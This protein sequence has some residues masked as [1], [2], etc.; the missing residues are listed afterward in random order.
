MHTHR[1]VQLQEPALRRRGRAAH[2]APPAGPGGG[3]LPAPGTSQGD[4]R[5][6]GNPA[7]SHLRRGDLLRAVPAEAGGQVPA[8]RSATARR[9]T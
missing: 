9:A 1:R 5:T 8:A 6:V 3:R 7:R 4:S 2:P